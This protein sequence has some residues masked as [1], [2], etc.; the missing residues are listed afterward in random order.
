MKRIDFY[1][2]GLEKSEHYRNFFKSRGN[3]NMEIKDEFVA[4]L[5]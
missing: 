1:I 2:P 4:V 5:E 3:Y